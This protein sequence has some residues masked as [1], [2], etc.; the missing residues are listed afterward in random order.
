MEN[1]Y[2]ATPIVSPVKESFFSD[3]SESETEE[4]GT[5]YPSQA[6]KMR[7]TA[8]SRQ[9]DHDSPKHTGSRNLKPKLDHKN[10]DRP[11][12]PKIDIDDYPILVPHPKDKDIWIQVYC[13][14]CKGNMRG[15]GRW[16]KGTMGAKRHM[17]LGKISFLLSFSFLKWFND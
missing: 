12:G 4:D 9:Q 5:Y 1:P 3:S 13:P 8:N 2:A 10:E 14:I 6:A 7:A 15:D 16:F 11:Q 17:R